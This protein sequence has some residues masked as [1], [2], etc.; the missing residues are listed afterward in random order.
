M[1]RGIPK[2]H[3][4]LTFRSHAIPSGR[5][6][7]RKHLSVV[8]IF[9]C[10]EWQGG[11]ETLIMTQEVMGGGELVSGAI[12]R[13]RYHIAPALQAGFLQTTANDGVRPETSERSF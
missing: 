4:G 13:C 7:F 6:T 12:S 1:L 3:A 8:V 9:A 11:Q 5:H 10:S 2:L